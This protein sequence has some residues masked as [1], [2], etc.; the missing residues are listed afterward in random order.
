MRRETT[1]GGF[2]SGLAL[3]V[4]LLCLVPGCGDDDAT[5]GADGG[6]G[7]GSSGTDAGGTP[8]DGG[9]NGVSCSDL[10]GEWKL[11]GWSCA[12]SSFDLASAGVELTM[13][14]SDSGSGEST[15]RFFVPVGQSATWYARTQGIDVQSDGSD[16]TFTPAAPAE[17]C[18]TNEVE[19]ADWGPVETGI[20]EQSCKNSTGAPGTPTS[21]VLACAASTDRVTLTVTAD[22]Q[23][24]PCSAGEESVETWV[25]Q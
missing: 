5:G 24:G 18:S 2:W 17:L 13:A 1:V 21:T 4:T 12:G 10:T 16:L 14:F 25:K 8:V 3:A 22:D 19:G 9:T 15:T 7:G 20:G 6:D 23:Y 11:A